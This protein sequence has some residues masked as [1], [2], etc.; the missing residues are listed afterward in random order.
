MVGNSTFSAFQ[1]SYSLGFPGTLTLFNTSGQPLITASISAYIT[2]V[3]TTYFFNQ[4]NRGGTFDIV[5]VPETST[6]LLVLT[7]IGAV[8][9]GRRGRTRTCDP[10]LRRNPGYLHPIHLLL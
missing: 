8:L 7:G 10:L 1:F 4:T 9:F 3:Q 6:S 2:N 5:A